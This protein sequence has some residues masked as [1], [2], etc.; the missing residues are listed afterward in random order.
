MFALLTA[1]SD[2]ST[3]ST[4]Q[5][6][7]LLQGSCDAQSGVRRQQLERN[8][9]A[10]RDERSLSAVA[11]RGRRES[12]ERDPGVISFGWLIAGSHP[13]LAGVT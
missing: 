13:P 11:L 6:T 1:Q 5:I 12:F 8:A 7:Q 4:L 2:A 10:M 3:A 9:P